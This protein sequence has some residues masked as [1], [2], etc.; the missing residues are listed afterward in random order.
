MRMLY[1]RSIVLVGLA[2]LWAVVAP[3]AQTQDR[4]QVKIPESGVP[5]IMTIEGKFVRVA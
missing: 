3:Q 5:Q 4:P 1:A 2:C